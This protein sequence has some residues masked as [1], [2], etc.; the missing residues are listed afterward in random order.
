MQQSDEEHVE[1]RG[2][3]TT[4][5]DECV[6]KLVTEYREAGFNVHIYFP[7]IPPIEL[8]SAVVTWVIHC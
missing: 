3:D 1:N 4:R 7:S 5:L 6:F 2:H 8:L